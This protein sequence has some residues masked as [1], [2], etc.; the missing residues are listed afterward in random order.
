M[1]F[2]FASLRAGLDP[3]KEKVAAQ[4]H[5]SA[6]RAPHEKRAIG[7]SPEERRA[8]KTE[9]QKQKRKQKAV[10]R[11]NH[12]AVLDF[13]TDPFD[14]IARER[15][16]PFTA[17]LYSENFDPVIIWDLDDASFL[18]RVIC[19]IEELPGEYIIYAHNGGKFDYLFMISKL[20]GKVSF[21]GR[22][23]MSAKIG[24][25]EIRD[26]YHLIPE[27]LSAYQKDDFDYSKLTKKNREKH[28]QDI[29]K[30]MVN[31]CLYT[32]QIVKAF[33][34]NYGCK[35]SIGQAAMA[36]IKQEYP[37]IKSI[38]EN[39]DSFLR[40]FFFGGRVECIQGR[41]V[42]EGDYKLYDVNSMYPYAMAN[43]QH[44]I[45]NSYRPRAGRPTEHTFFVDLD[46]FSRGAFPVKRP[47]LGTIFPTE[48][49]RFKVSIH[50]YNAALELGLISKVKINYCV[51]CFEHTDFSR[52]IN[53]LYHSRQVAKRKLKT[54]T[55]QLS[56]EYL[57]TK[58]DDLFFKLLMNNAYGKFCQNPRNFKEYWI[59]DANGEPEHER[60]TWGTHPAELCRDYAIWSRPIQTLRFNNVG[61]GASITGVARSI[62]LRA[63]TGATDAVYCDTDSLVCRSLAGV[64]LDPVA[65]GAWDCEAEISRIMIAGKKLYGYETADGT[66]KIRC[67]GGSGMTWEML[68]QVTGGD[69]VTL[70]ARA[71]TLTRNGNQ[72]YIDRRIRA[73]V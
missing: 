20:R 35:L 57:D 58:K 1:N 14:M 72:A 40:Q 39:D 5:A 31:D 43:Y 24:N 70:P 22:G 41:G 73:T 18:T 67:K 9:W 47:G 51:D 26:S 11:I 56:Q 2:D 4:K 37:E 49:G 27:K 15:I 8:A 13:E 69:V 19:A 32:Y 59:T 30:Y 10:D 17:C 12:I 62:L 29:I 50:E 36:L 33:L 55:D 46:C 54:I 63:R 25:H 34:Q 64:S 42:W 61:T 48:Y 45:G 21:K 65:L 68:E 28:R 44:P 71:P 16:A 6:K 23:I 38:H 53:P 52:F 66:R 3:A 7:M 60:D